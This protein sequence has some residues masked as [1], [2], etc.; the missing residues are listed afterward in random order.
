[1]VV[2]TIASLLFGKYFNLRSGVT[3]IETP[4]TQTKHKSQHEKAQRPP[5]N[6]PCIKTE[7][8]SPATA[9]AGAVFGSSISINKTH[10]QEPHR[11]Q[12]VGFGFRR[13]GGLVNGS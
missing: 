9:F 1:M 13:V 5:Y 6:K 3:K 11:T 4:P 2:S 8:Q 7:P 10:T 12:S